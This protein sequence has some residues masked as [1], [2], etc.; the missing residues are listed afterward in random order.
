MLA[1][2]HHLPGVTVV[3]VIDADSGFLSADFRAPERTA[4]L[5]VQVAGRAGRA[6]RPGEVWIQT[7]DPD[8]SN[9]RALVEEGYAGFAATEIAH[10]REAALPPFA[11]M[12]VL[13]AESVDGA[14]CE[15]LLERAAAVL[16]AEPAGGGRFEVL[17]PAP[18]PMAR[19]GGRLRFQCLVLA[20]GRRRLHAA[21][22]RLEEAEMPRAKVRWSIDVDPY[23]TF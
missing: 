17:G 18:A 12:A 9:L 1:K 10:R 15:A 5:I 3:A 4:Q 7:Y 6:E 13:R 22:G 23:D 14:A 16:R 8:N 19:R 21:L 20:D 2:G 11:A